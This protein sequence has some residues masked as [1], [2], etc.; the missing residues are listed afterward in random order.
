MYRAL[1]RLGYK[2]V[3]IPPGRLV[4]LAGMPLEHAQKLVE[5]GAI[6]VAQTLPLSALLGWRA[7]AAKLATRGIMDVA[8]VVEVTPEVLAE[9]L[10]ATVN[11]ARKWQAEC[12]QYLTAPAEQSGG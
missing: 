4:T 11:A 10:G 1:A 6:E 9:Y 5:V 7:R 3:D 8:Q 2:G 12:Q